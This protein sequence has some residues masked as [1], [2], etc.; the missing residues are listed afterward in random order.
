MLAYSERLRAIDRRIWSVAPVILVVVASAAALQ[1]A[2]RSGSVGFGSQMFPVRA[3]DFLES[4]ANGARVFAKDQWGG[5]LIYRF[6]GNMKVFI[7]GRSDFYGQNFLETYAE[8][9]EARPGWNAVL[10]QYAV[11]FVMAAPKTALVSV[12]RLSPEWKAVYADS[13]ALVFERND[14]GRAQ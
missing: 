11:Q 9:A 6:S 10:D 7:D 2:G 5:Y 4:H 8:V 3:A 12:L 14:G 13:V 1:A